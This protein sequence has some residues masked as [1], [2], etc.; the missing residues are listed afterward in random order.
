MPSASAT[1]AE[2]GQRRRDVQEVL[3]ELRRH[4]LVDAIDRRQLERD[5][6]HVERVHRHPAGGVG[7]IEHS[8][9][10]QRRVAVEHAD[11]V[12]PEEA[13]LKHVAP[14]GVLAVHPPG[15]VEQQLVEDA[16]EERIVGA[17]A[18]IA[19]VLEDAQRRPGVHRR[20]DVAERPLRTPA[21]GRSGACTTRAAAARAAPS[22]PPDPPRE[23]HAVE[24]GVPGREPGYSQVSGIERTSEALK[25]THS[26]LR[27]RRRS[28]GGAGC[29]G[30][31]CSHTGTS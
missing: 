21:A 11:V 10:G 25:C 6:Q 18:A 12:E 22:P 2:I 24:G 7:L 27:P 23:R 1:G 3:E 15:E 30:S 9:R 19:L 20:I 4:V 8:A 13:A 31:P 14:V 16:L 5:A 26:A 29:A 17:A 28:A